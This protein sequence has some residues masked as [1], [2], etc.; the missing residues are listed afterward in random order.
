MYWVSTIQWSVP[1]DNNNLQ[2]YLVWPQFPTHNILSLMTF[3]TIPFPVHITLED[4]TSEGLW[5]L[6]AGTV[7]VSSPILVFTSTIKK[8]NFD[9]ST[10]LMVLYG[11]CMF[12]L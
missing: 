7:F 8:S 5:H 9:N 1:S 10:V 4:G 3:S 2:K 6:F 12:A 11:F